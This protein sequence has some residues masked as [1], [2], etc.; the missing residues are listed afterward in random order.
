MKKVAQPGILTPSRGFSIVELLLAVGLL[1]MTALAFSG[2]FTQQIK[3]T[4]FLEFQTK[5]EQL[6]LA[7]L[8]QFLSDSNNCKCLFDGVGEFSSTGHS[9]VLSGPKPNQI[10]PYNFA[11]AGACNTATIPAALIT[12]DGF[13]GL[14]LDSVTLGDITPVSGGFQGQFVVRITSMKEVI[15]PST[16]A[17]KIP[18]AVEV[19]PGATAG[20]VLFNGCSLSGSKT[21]AVN[22]AGLLKSV[23][24]Y[25]KTVCLR[26]RSNYLYEVSQQCP[27]GYALIGCAGG[28]GDQDERYEAFWIV[29]NFDTNTCTLMINKPACTASQPVSY[30]KVI[31]LCFPLQ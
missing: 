17:L 11:T 24:S 23:K 19:T 18:V 2:L 5:K 9:G 20:R 7:L 26:S 6:R 22:M 10:G 14:K 30:Q 1:S 3:A 12:R 13:D 27:N 31:A 16:L 15:G 25:Q 21:T 28:P 4:N 29:P 8:G